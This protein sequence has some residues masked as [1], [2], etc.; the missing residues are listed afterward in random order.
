MCI[1]RSRLIF[2]F[3]LVFI[4]FS[5]FVLKGMR[6]SQTGN[7]ITDIAVGNSHAMSLNFKSMGL[8]G[9]NHYIPSA[10]IIETVVN[11][12]EVLRLYEG[13]ERVWI[14]I[15]PVLI[16]R[17]KQF[18]GL[19]WFEELIPFSVVWHYNVVSNDF[20][21]WGL[22]KSYIRDIRCKILSC[23]TGSMILVEGAP[24]S[25]TTVDP[26]DLTNLAYNTVENHTE[27][28]SLENDTNVR[29]FKKLLSLAEERNVKVLLFTPPYT[30]YY[31]NDPRMSSYVDRY[32]NE[33]NSLIVNSDFAHYL[34]FHDLYDDKNYNFF[35]DDDHLNLK[36]AIHFSP[37]LKNAFTEKDPQVFSSRL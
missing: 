26:N 23:D 9:V 34:D 7:E 28:A 2:I 14:P 32:Q 19:K 37:L 1:L 22:P 4:I 16:Y 36:G 5:P 29:Y 3:T 6:V 27:Y 31:Y 15:A 11:F 24:A 25:I 17:N 33:I 21:A 18:H 12:K 20:L 30:D 10:G 13:I 8:F 35:H